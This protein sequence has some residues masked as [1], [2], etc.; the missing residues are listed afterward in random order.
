[1]KFY[2]NPILT[3]GI[4]FIFPP[5]GI[6]LLWALNLYSLLIRSL[7]T[8][9]FGLLYLEFLGLYSSVI[10]ALIYSIVF[11]FLIYR[12][13]K[14]S[15]LTEKVKELYI[16]A[17]N[18][19]E[20]TEILKNYYV[21]FIPFTN[22]FKD[23]LTFE[24]YLRSKYP[25]I[26]TNLTLVHLEDT[27]IN[28]IYEPSD[29]ILEKERDKLETDELTKENNERFN[30]ELNL[31]TEIIKKKIKL[32]GK[33]FSFYFT[34]CLIKDFATKYYSEIFITKYNEL[35]K[36]IDIKN[37]DDVLLR[38]VSLDYLNPDL[39]SQDFTMF[40]Y[41]LMKYGC[42]SNIIDFYECSI[43]INN[44]LSKLTEK[45]KDQLFKKHLFTNTN[46]L[47]K[48]IE[49]I[50]VVNA[51]KTKER[52]TEFINDLLNALGYKDINK[53]LNKYLDF[54]VSEGNIKIGI[55]T[56]YHE[57]SDSI[58]NKIIQDGVLGLKYNEVN[59]VM[60]MTNGKFSTYS[61]ELAKA[62][63]IILWDKEI[64]IEKINLVKRYNINIT[65]S[66]KDIVF[67]D[68][69]TIPFEKIKMDNIDQMAGLEFEYYLAE[70]FKRKSY[71]IK[72]INKTKDKGID[73]ILEYNG[74]QIGIQA[75]R[76]KNKIDNN[77][78]KE[79]LA[80]IPYYNL[81]KAYCITNN[82]FNDEAKRLGECFN[83]VL[84]DRN[85]LLSEM[86]KIIT[87]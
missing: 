67:N 79:T 7:L 19:D 9:F 35:F 37:F 26:H 58:S 44:S 71:K 61:E 22:C 87:N 48:E 52:F 46:E 73:I 1:M 51:M 64:L 76:S 78:I 16:D 80:G 21:K 25:I 32:S 49:S 31:L 70:L 29:Y 84:W 10:R 30:K 65:S 45:R 47:L 8:L 86:E 57:G 83:I 17:I 6:V 41:Y 60:I 85:I 36:D 24:L 75:K 33:K 66:D 82:F 11:S 20:I 43:K 4:L 50:E 23:L 74:V 54:I 27:F 69:S 53:P 40:T 28:L 3:W 63:P 42:F 38:Y 34:F 18:N 2:H 55:I 72:K 5:L 81:D 56:H 14:I 12:H 59:K 15:N 77:S 62:Y 13:Y 68:I 39:N